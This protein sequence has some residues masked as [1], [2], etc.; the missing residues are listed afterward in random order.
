L[1]KSRIQVDAPL[2]PDQLLSYDNVPGS[3]EMPVE[4]KKY[5]TTSRLIMTTS[6]KGFKFDK[7]NHQ[8]SIDG[9][10]VYEWNL[11]SGTF[12]GQLVRKVM[13]LKTKPPPKQGIGS[14]QI[15]PHKPAWA[16]HIYHPKRTIASR[17]IIMPKRTITSRLHKEVLHRPKP[18][19]NGQVFYGVYGVDDRTVYYPSGY[20]WQCVGR[21]FVYINQWQNWNWSGSGV[22]VG[23]RVVLTAGH[24]VPWDV[25]SPSFFGMLF[26]PGY[27]DGVSVLGGGARSWV[28]QASG[29]SVSYYSRYPD[30]QDM[31]VLRLQDPLGDSL[32]YFGSKGY[33]NDWQSM[34]YFNLTG[35]PGMVAGAERPSYEPGIEVM[36]SDANGDFVELEFQDDSTPGD[37]GAP[38]WATWSD[39]FPYVIGTISGGEATSEEDNNIAAGGKGMDDLIRSARTNWP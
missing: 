28:T 3:S 19:R 2:T 36:D 30:A 11:P 9:D 21:I 37:S 4:L 7:Q 17:G 26:V 18:H 12:V 39:G 1:K 38:F 20:P 5:L 35:Y 27:Y 24:V 32:G 16:D 29:Y 15:R 22:L 25:Q 10:Y 31:A 8:H 34:R 6:E 23:P 14:A 33:F 13:D